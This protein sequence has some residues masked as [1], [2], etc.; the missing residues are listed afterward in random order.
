MPRSRLLT[1]QARRDATRAELQA[2]KD[3]IDALPTATPRELGRLTADTLRAR[4]GRMALMVERDSLS[5]RMVE[6]TQTIGANIERLY[7]A[8]DEVAARSA[9]LD[10]AMAAMPEDGPEA[11]PEAVAR[12]GTLMDAE[13]ERLE[14]QKKVRRLVRRIEATERA[15]AALPKKVKKK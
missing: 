9:Q 4:G 3:Q 5:R 2:L 15:I 14:L 7:L 12:I 8:M 10:L 11:P 6:I 1:L 13:A